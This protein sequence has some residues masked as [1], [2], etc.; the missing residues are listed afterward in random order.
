VY[1]GYRGEAIDGQ[2]RSDIGATVQEPKCAQ[3]GTREQRRTPL[4]RLS[5]RR[6]PGD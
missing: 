1:D 6:L 5:D 3:I 2:T 4:Q